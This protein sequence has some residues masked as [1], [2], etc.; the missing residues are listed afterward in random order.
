MGVLRVSIREF[1]EKLATNLLGTDEMVAIT[2]H[3]HTVGYYIPARRKRSDSERAALKEAASRLQEM[4]AVQGVSEQ[5]FPERLQAMAPRHG[6]NPKEHTASTDGTARRD[7]S[8]GG[9]GRG[10]R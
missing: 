5:E 9:G 3:G 8:E 1:R 10:H 2:R 7:G 4:L 6:R